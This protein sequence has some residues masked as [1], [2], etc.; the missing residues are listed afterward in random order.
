MLETKKSELAE[1][2]SDV[3]AEIEK[4]DP[5]ELWKLHKAVTEIRY[6]TNMAKY[7]KLGL[8]LAPMPQF[9]VNAE[10]YAPG[11]VLPYAYANGEKVHG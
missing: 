7:R 6:A 9:L 5:T 10:T 2:K 1:L 11:A 4:M 3:L 8:L